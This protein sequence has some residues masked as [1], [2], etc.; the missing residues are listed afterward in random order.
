MA[1]RGRQI[2]RGGCRVCA[3]TAQFPGS[4]QICDASCGHLMTYKMT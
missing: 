3:Y 1:G 4:H 2:A